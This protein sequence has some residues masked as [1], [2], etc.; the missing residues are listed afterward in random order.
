MIGAHIW[1]FNFHE[2]QPAE[3]KVG[4]DGKPAG[5]AVPKSKEERVEARDAL[6]ISSFC[7]TM[8][9]NGEVPSPCCVPVKNWATVE[10][11]GMR[12]R[13]FMRIQLLTISCVTTKV[14]SVRSTEALDSPSSV[15]PYQQTP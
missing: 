9:Y 6:I 15:D 10:V 11:G 4:R 2:V 14:T 12:V 7:K 8:A 13:S 1:E 3:P 5:R